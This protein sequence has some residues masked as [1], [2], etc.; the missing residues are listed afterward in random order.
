MKIYLIV[1]QLSLAV[2]IALFQVEAQFT[3]NNDNQPAAQVN[4]GDTV[5]P[6]APPSNTYNN[7]RPS[8][9][10][11]NINNNINRPAPAPARPDP[12][13]TSSPGNAIFPNKFLYMF[14]E[15]SQMRKMTPGDRSRNSADSVY[16]QVYHT[17]SL[18]LLI[19]FTYFI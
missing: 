4:P 15:T 8:T 9:G 2:F 6:S 3:F 12:T 7:D 5:G 16:R 18:P 1:L 13:P 11:N 10:N 14:N 17:L 19:A